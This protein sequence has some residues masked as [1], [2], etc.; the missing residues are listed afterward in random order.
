MTPIQ[1]KQ[2]IAARSLNLALI[3]ASLGVSAAAVGMTINRRITSVPIARAIARAIDTDF[4]TVFP[5]YSNTVP[6]I[7]AKIDA[8]SVENL[9]EIIR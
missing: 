7:R 4:L 9:R 6:Q 8:K 2:A 3:A 5:D 1:I